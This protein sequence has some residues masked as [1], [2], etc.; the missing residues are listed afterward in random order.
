MQGV[1]SGEAPS[2]VRKASVADGAFFLMPR[3]PLPYQPLFVFRRNR[4]LHAM[5]RIGFA[6]LAA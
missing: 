1:T 5:I 3:E 2:F 4:M 6:I